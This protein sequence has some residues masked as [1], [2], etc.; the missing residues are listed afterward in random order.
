VRRND[1]GLKLL[2]CRYAQTLP[3]LAPGPGNTFFVIQ[4]EVTSALSGIT[5]AFT[6]ALPR[7]PVHTRHGTR[8]R[9]DR[10]G[11][12]RRGTC[13]RSRVAAAAETDG[14]HRF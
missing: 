9:P 2:A 8:G 7:S 12:G 4:S 6:E 14:T 10:T 5:T 11:S 1:P 13:S 3:H